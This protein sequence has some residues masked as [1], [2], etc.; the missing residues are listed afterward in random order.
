MPAG[1]S[2]RGERRTTTTSICRDN[3]NR[4]PSKLPVTISFDG[5][6][7]H[8]LLSSLRRPLPSAFPTPA[9]GGQRGCPRGLAP[10]L[11]WLQGA[12]AGGR[13]KPCGRTWVVQ[14]PAT[15][16]QPHCPSRIQTTTMT[17]LTT[18]VADSGNMDDGTPLSSSSTT[19]TTMKKMT[20]S[21]SPVSASLPASLHCCV[22]IVVVVVIAGPHRLCCRHCPCLVPSSRQP[23]S[24]PPLRCM[25]LERRS[26]CAR[27]EGRL[28][29]RLGRE[30][31]HY[32]KRRHEKKE[33][34]SHGIVR[35][36]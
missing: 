29:T 15:A 12:V 1:R 23:L 28:L 18:T 4:P 11:S 19:T 8:I 9:T 16:G 13:T 33:I 26:S 36:L 14:P 22:V 20:A 27:V 10:T 2:P 31:G 5:L 25:T 24:P 21:S 30:E 17:V 35:V 34:I 6:H 32:L 3:G 7:C